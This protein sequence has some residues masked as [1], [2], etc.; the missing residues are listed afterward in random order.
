MIAVSIVLFVVFGFWEHHLEHRTTLP[1][2]VKMS[3]FSRH[4][5]KFTAINFSAFAIAFSVY[6]LIYSFAI[7][8]QDYQGLSALQNALRLIP[9]NVSG[10]L[11]A[12]SICHW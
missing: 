4:G 8:Y 10:A 3:L 6:S 7:Y 11:A 2:V 12:V 5:W 1:P 9:A